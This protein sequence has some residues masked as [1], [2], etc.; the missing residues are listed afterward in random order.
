MG[1]KKSSP[2]P[3]VQK[4]AEVTLAEKAKSEADAQAAAAAK[5]AADEA[6]TT[7]AARDKAIQGGESAADIAARQ[8][9]TLANPVKQRIKGRRSL[10]SG[11]IGSGVSA[12]R[13]QLG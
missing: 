4:F 10:V 12:G 13:E 6:A 2:P 8:T 3:G 9:S 11:A 1:S 5:V 7:K